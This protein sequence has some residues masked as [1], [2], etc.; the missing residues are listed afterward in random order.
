MRKR[1]DIMVTSVHVQYWKHH[2]NNHLR[3]PNTLLPAF[4]WSDND[5]GPCMKAGSVIRR[6]AHNFVK[7]WR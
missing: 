3:S 7:I 6:P 2:E 1:A 5:S 4:D